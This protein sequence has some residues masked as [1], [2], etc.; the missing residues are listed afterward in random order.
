MLDP[1]SLILSSIV[2]GIIVGPLARLIIP[3]PDPMSILQTMLVGVAGSLSAYLTTRYVFDHEGAPGL[4]PSVL[5]AAILVFA[6]RK[7]R[8]RQLGPEGAAAGSRSA[9][10]SPLGFGQS[11]MQVR[12]MPG[13][14]VGSLLASV[15]LTVLL[16][17]LVRAF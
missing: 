15:I 14:L 7:L 11:N 16:N 13:C 9:G 6:V 17:L 12:F 3:G 8:E 5:C 1:A 2:L 4:L 10:A